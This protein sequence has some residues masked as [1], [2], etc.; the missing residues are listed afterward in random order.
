MIRH[1]L[2]S[3]AILAA[4]TAAKADA[5]YSGSMLY[6]YCTTAQ[7]TNT[8][9]AGTTAGEAMQFNE[10]SIK[11]FRGCRI[12]AIAIANGAQ[13]PG[14][15]ATSMPISIFLTDDLYANEFA[16]T[17]AGEMDLT[18]PF[19][20]KEYPLAE[21][22]EIT[23]DTKPFYAGFSVV[24]DPAAGYPI[25]T[26]GRDNQTAGPGDWFGMIQGGSWTWEQLR[27]QAGFCCVRLKIEGDALPGNAVSLM[28][29][30]LPTYAAPG[31]KATV[32]MYLQNDAGNE[33]SSVNVT[34]TVNNGAPRVATVALPRP[35]LYND[36]TTIPVEFSVEMPQTQ[37]A[38]LPFAIEV[39]GINADNAANNAAKAART[40]SGTYLSL[41]E[42]FDKAMVAEIATGTWC[43]FCPQGFVAVEK[44]QQKYPGSGRFIPIAVHINDEYTVQ[45]YAQLPADYTG[46]GSAPSVVVN[47]NVADFGVQV[48]SFEFFDDAYRQITATPSLVRPEITAVSFD[49]AKKRISVD[50]AV[51]FAIPATGEYAFSYA[52]TE[53]KVGPGLQ[54]NYYS[55]ATGQGYKLE[56][57]DEQPEY[58]EVMFGSVA[59]N[60]YSF[61]GI[62]GSIPASVEPGR[63]YSHTG[64][65]QTNPVS[66][67]EN[68]HIILMVVNRTTGR[69][70][71]AVSLPFSQWS[72]ISAIDAGP[73]AEPTR[74]YDLQGRPTE[75]PACG[76]VYIRRTPSGHT[77]KVIF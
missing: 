55:P 76:K 4:A 38:D 10:S 13:A 32:G 72:G 68:C 49:A 33:V 62:K 71:N 14:S 66:N 65:L 57:W 43:G 23:A 70:E 27:S 18:R 54:H 73:T 42:G 35:L 45:S 53:D 26:D 39:S 59:R 52:L 2:T 34:Y 29:G 25:V 8:F 58:V 5:T 60:I 22:I 61:R 19:E 16:L 17:M 1:L 3:F 9:N 40:A 56:W 28:A 24:C 36:Y 20:Y 15:A 47:R 41:A 7:A 50:A 77:Q 64:T 69:I 31:G 6:G 51:E 37:G 44:M 74:Y 11:Y 12:T 46:E 48:P 21:P 75:H 63:S 67:I 30:S